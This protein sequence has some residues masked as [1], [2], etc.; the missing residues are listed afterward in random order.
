[1]NFVLAAPLFGSPGFLVS[2]SPHASQIGW[3]VLLGVALGALSVGIAVTICLLVR[4][5]APAL[6]LWLL[7]LATA[8]LAAAVAEQISVLSMLSLSEAYANAPT[9]E[10]GGFQG[11]RT[12]VASARNWSHYIG[13]CIA[14]STIFVMYAT[15]YRAAL[16][17]RALAA[18]GHDDF[19]CADEIS[20][21]AA[22]AGKFESA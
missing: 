7:A 4:D 8:S 17:P 10:Q 5:R 6:T 20:G 14:G 13:L 19:P 16:V 18:F 3:S 9:A 2:A 21:N 11:L 22:D 15:L 1:M 12:V